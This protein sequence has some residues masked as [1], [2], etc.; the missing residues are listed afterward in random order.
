MIDLWIGSVQII[1]SGALAAGD[2]EERAKAGNELSG[3]LGI[4]RLES[5]NSPGYDSYMRSL[6]RIC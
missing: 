1:K 5:R 4:N 2:W 6:R 3:I